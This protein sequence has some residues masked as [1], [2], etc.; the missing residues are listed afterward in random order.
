MNPFSNDTPSELSDRVGNELREAA[1]ALAVSG[2]PKRAV[3]RAE[4]RRRR[5]TAAT[6]AAGVVAVAGLGAG[7]LALRPDASSSV[8]VAS[9]ADPIGPLDDRGPL[10]LEWRATDADVDWP[11][12]SFVGTDGYRYALS[13]APGARYGDLDSYDRVPQAVYRSADG[14]NWESVSPGETYLQGL[15]SRNG[16]L[17]SV[18]TSA[19]ADGKV[20]SSVVSSVDHGSEWS[21]VELPFV[22]DEVADPNGLLYPNVGRPVSLAVGDTALL[23]TG[24]ETRWFDDAK[25]AEFLGLPGASLS[26]E[27]VNGPDERRVLVRDYGPC[28]EAWEVMSDE[29]E[30]TEFSADPPECADPAIV[31]DVSLAELGLV[32]DLAQTRS[33]I[34]TDGVSWEPVEVP[35]DQVWFAGGVYLAART[36]SANGISYAR[37]ID[38]VTWSPIDSGPFDGLEVVGASNGVLVGRAYR[39]VSSTNVLTLSFDAGETWKD[40]AVTDLSSGADPSSYVVTVA[41]GDLGIVVVLGDGASEPSGVDGWTIVTSNDAEQWTTQRVDEVDGIDAGYPGWAFVDADRMGVVFS[42]ARRNADG[43]VQAMTVLGTPTR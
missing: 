23:A 34:S 2:D 1:R 12:A 28:N 41:A 15:G 19:A 3:E 6:A 26:H 11:Q 38:G 29:G 42:G 27:L 35:G 4:Q 25:L 21:G 32:G 31:A 18:S 17:Y 20:V 40:L 39:S 7:A 8:V 22:F 43:T 5:R 13:T 9:A 10:T 14:E 24:S 36:E 16:V 37:S 30:I 33:L